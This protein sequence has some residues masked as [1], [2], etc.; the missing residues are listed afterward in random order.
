MTKNPLERRA[1]SALLPLAAALLVL[2]STPFAAAQSS[3]N[4]SPPAGRD[5]SKRDG[6]TNDKSPDDDKSGK[7]AKKSNRGGARTKQRQLGD[8]ATEA[9]LQLRLEPE[10]RRA[11]DR[12]L[13]YTL[14]AI[15]TE[16]VEWIGGDALTVEAMRGRVVVIQSLSV[17]S[18]WRGVVEGLRRQIED[19]AEAPADAPTGAQADTPIVILLHTPDGA[20]KA[21]QVLEPVLDGWRAVVDKDGAWCDA[22]GVWKKPVNLV[23]DRNGIVRYAA[24]TPPGVGAAV[25]ILLAETADPSAAPKVREEVASAT[26]ATF[27][28]FRDP[29]GPAADRR[30]QSMPALQVQ[31]W[32]NGQ[33]DPGQRLVVIDFWATWCPP[34]RASIPHMNQLAE[35]FA[36]EVCFVGLSDE[37]RSNF[38]EGCRKHDL[39]ERDFKYALALDSQKRLASF[40]AVKGI[41]HCVAVSADGVVRWQ[42]SP[43]DLTDDVLRP[44]IGANNALA[45]GAGGGS[46]GWKTA[47]TG[48]KS[49]G[50]GAAPP[51][52]KRY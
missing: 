28:T 10:D 27:P 8:P 26:D 40:F 36:S 21:R 19:A 25:E 51:P 15:P 24:L 3:G 23:V 11:L 13:Q 38:D 33:P 43:K 4:T 2:A 7:D 6:G 35:R 49:A 34:C 20:D 50:G 37:S 45:S 16:N 9:R 44:M 18:N 5:T 48:G 12:A 29:V 14:P 47:S 17:R 41:P 31:T 1:G 46:R 30:G 39:K 52:R 32:L 22:L 42:G